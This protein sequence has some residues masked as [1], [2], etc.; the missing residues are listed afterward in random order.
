[1]RISGN[2]DSGNIECVSDCSDPT[3]IRLAINKDRN[4]RLLSVVSPPASPGRAAARIARC[5]SRTPEAPPIRRSWEN[6]RACAS[7]IA[8]TL[9]PRGDR[10]RRDGPDDQPSHGP[11][12]DPVFTHVLH[13][14][15]LDGTAY[16]RRRR[17]GARQAGVRPRSPGRHHGRTGHGTLCA[18]ARPGGE[19]NRT[20]AI[21]SPV[22][23]HPGRP[24]RNG[25]SKGSTDR[26]LDP[27]TAVAQGT[28]G[29]GRLPHRSQHESRRQPARP[30]AQP[31]AAGANLNRHDGWSRAWS[32]ARRSSSFAR[33]CGRD[34]GQFL[35]RRA[36][37]RDGPLQLPRQ[38]DG[39]SSHSR[40]SRQRCGGPMR[41][42]CRA[43]A[44]TSR[45]SMVIP[46]TRPARRT[47]RCA[48][49]TSPRPSAVSR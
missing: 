47:S 30:S 12:H 24:W 14:A 27:A 39:N 11:E 31:M 36:W 29:A 45:P 48:A 13:C 8:G 46:T 44:R 10:V 25:G 33:R 4:C 37:R 7:M 23:Q 38:D 43:P 20:A 5:G 22:A 40:P 32:A 2:F 41:S 28:A 42:S 1:M 21:A 19:A 49:T 9:V 17:G 16:A 3:D 18:W 35:P 15:L 26:L 6:Y 34:R